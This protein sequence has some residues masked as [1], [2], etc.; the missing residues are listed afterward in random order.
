MI[1]FVNSYYMPLGDGCYECF[2]ICNPYTNTILS[3][4]NF[5]F[6]ISNGILL[7]NVILCS[8]W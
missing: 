6:G 4:G 1:S 2:D 7:K 8:R 3:S 5:F